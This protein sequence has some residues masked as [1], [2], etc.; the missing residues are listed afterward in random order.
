MENTTCGVDPL[1]GATRE[2]RENTFT[3]QLYN[4]YV[5]SLKQG[6]N[7]T[8]SD[9]RPFLAKKFQ[10]GIKFRKFFILIFETEIFIF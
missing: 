2:S 5:A 4:P 8:F 3:V 10:K 1:F 7:F 9:F 6:D